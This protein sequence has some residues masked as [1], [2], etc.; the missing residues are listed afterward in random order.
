MFH[1]RGQASSTLM[2]NHKSLHPRLKTNVAGEIR[3]VERRLEDARDALDR[4]NTARE[5]ARRDERDAKEVTQPTLRSLC[6][7]MVNSGC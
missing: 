3:M 1:R 6:M 7:S 4:A 2:R 5:D